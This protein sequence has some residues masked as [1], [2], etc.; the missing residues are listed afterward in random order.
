MQPSQQLFEFAYYCY[1]RNL[2]T[3]TKTITTEVQ[4]LVNLSDQADLNSPTEILF[5]MGSS[6]C[7]KKLSILELTWNV[8]GNRVSCAVTQP[9]HSHIKMSRGPET[10]PQQGQKSTSYQ[11]E[12]RGLCVGRQANCPVST[13][14]MDRQVMGDQLPLLM[15]ILLSFLFVS[16][17]LFHP[18]FNV[19]CFPWQHQYQHTMGRIF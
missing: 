13:A 11:C 15:H 7:L 6:M 1:F 18:G 5:C 10:F 14:R 9:L 16:K 17:V 19:L 4:N 2:K 3:I 12:T 8:L